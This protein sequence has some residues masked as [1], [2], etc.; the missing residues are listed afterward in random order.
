MRNLAF[1]LSE[2]RY[3]ARIL[4]KT[5]ALTGAVVLTVAL[6]IGANTAMFSVI[7]AV[8]LKPLQYRDS[9]RVVLVAEGATPI[10]FEEIRNASRSYSAVGAF[11]VGFEE[12]PFSGVPDPEVLKAARVSANFLQIL[13]VS[14][15]R[16]R[17]F[18]PDEDQ[19][20]APLVTMISAE[21]WQ[22]RFSG[23]ASIV[24]K[25]IT[26]GGV[27]HTILGVLPPR[28]QFP[29]A[30]ADVWITR[31]SEWSVIPPQNQAISPILSVFSRLRDGTDLH[32]AS[33]ELAVLNR[34]YAAAHPGMLDIK[35]N[36]SEPVRPLKDV[37]IADIDSK[38]WLL[39]GAVALVWLIVCANVG[40]LLLA[41]ASSRAREFA[42]RVAIGAGRGRVIG[43]L[44]TESLLL[45]L[46]GGSLGVLLAGSALRAIRG[47]TVIDLPRAAEI[48]MDASVLGFGLAL[49]LLTGVLF[50][51]LPAF[52]ASR[53]DLI[54]V[55]KGSGEAMSATSHRR[56]LRLSPRGLLVAG[57]VA[58][59]VVLLI[60]ATL[61]I[62]SLAHLYRVDPGFQAAGL[63]TMKIDLPAARYDSDAKKAA[64]Y[65]HLIEKVQSL[66]GV[67]NVATTRT[68]PVDE[69]FGTTV[70]ATGR[71]SIPLNERPIAIFQNITPG[72]FRTMEI[73]LKRGREFT[74]HD[75]AQ[76]SPVLIVNEKLAHLFWRQYPAGPDPI[77]QHILTGTD[78]QPAEIVGITADVHQTGRDASPRAEIYFPAA[79]KPSQTAMLAV[80]TEGDPM[81]FA[82]LVRNEILAIDHD[83]PVS[84]VSTMEDVLDASA[85]EL[86][87]MMR[88]LGT[89]AVAATLLTV[90]GLYG[91][92]SYTVLQRTKEIGI[93]QALGAPRSNIL[94]LVV[95][96]GL[97]LGLLG[98]LLGTC[99]ALACTRLMEDLLFQVSANDPS[100]FLGVAVLFI[101]VAVGASY[102]PA[103]RALGIDPLDALRIV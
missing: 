17:A 20:G 102:I 55:L 80:R 21:L 86:R 74:T 43:Q 84:A 45:A 66:P 25:T 60:G 31:P 103:R 2:L 9:N 69:F 67:R 68:L 70:Q 93:R 71:P 47:V 16:G 53:P 64:F 23:D 6:G 82:N 96:Q 99:A 29:M 11:A 51:L 30:G 42:V 34:Q 61:L 59:S 87:L 5:P 40:S 78:P 62:E 52:A 98:V 90:I 18:L 39:F 97:V 72:Y 36:S 76:A 35:P 73:G 3:A 48:R 41:R 37:L 65:N 101:L 14:P 49:S 46:S 24:G 1:F 100:T 79:Q 15:I 54:A 27:P 33:A 92:I 8:L 88:L 44:L 77:G 91:I 4:R 81:S 26:L 13:D 56:F 22:R 28:F 75:N 83:E 19:A 50:G 85:G 38:L 12:M 57:Q 94:L 58:L 95:R 7:H 32:Q 89:F 10:R 63:L